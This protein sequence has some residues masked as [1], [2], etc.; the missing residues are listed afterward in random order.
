MAGA[1]REPVPAMLLLRGRVLGARVP[2]VGSRWLGGLMVELETGARVH[3]LMP[4]AIARWMQRGERVEVRFLE[5][6]ENLGGVYVAPRDTF[7]LWR[8]WGGEEG[9]ERIQVWPLWRR[10]ARLER[11]SVL[12][13]KVYEYRVVAR[14]AES[15]E[16]FKEIV[17]LEQYHYASKEEVVAIWRC[18]VCGAYAE[19][20]VQPTCPRCGVPMK[21]Q[22]IRGSLPSSRFMVL[23]LVSREP[24]EPRIVA[25]VRVDTPIPLMHRRIVRE[26]GRVEIERMI[27]GEDVPPGLVPPDLLAPGLREEGRA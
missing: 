21:L 11:E 15:E 5:E 12:G 1:R 23:E 6:P 13:E 7:E 3:L 10:E 26:D 27:R 19:A 4:G 9:E 25:Y 14:E 16:D 17:G 18:P 20:N 22:E 24:Y 8:I 2:R